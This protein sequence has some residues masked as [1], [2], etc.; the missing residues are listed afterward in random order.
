MLDDTD[1][2]LD[3]GDDDGGGSW[4]DSLRGWSR[5]L[6]SLV[7]F[8]GSLVFLFWN[9]SSGKQHADAIEE[10]GESARSIS[11]AAPLDPTL[12]GQPVHLS[13][14]VTSAGGVRDPFFG[15]R[16]NS[17][18]LF[19]NVAMFQW[20]EYKETRGKGTKRRT[21]YHYEQ[22]W[23]TSWHDSSRFHEPAGHQNPPMDLES[24]AFFAEDARFGPYRFTNQDVLE[25]ALHEYE[26][27]A[28]GERRPGSL[29]N[30]P[31]YLEQLPEL[32]AE[33]TRQRWF[34]IAPDEYY[35]GNEGVE[36]FEIG[37]L[38]VSYYAFPTDYTL[39]MIAGQH[40]DQLTAWTAGNGDTVLLA[41][42]GTLDAAAVITE[43]LASN[44]SRIA[45][46]RVVGLIGSM[47]GFVGMISSVAGLL[48]MIPGIGRLI[49]MSLVI[50]G[51]VI[52]LFL[53]LSTIVLGWLVARP[54]IGLLLLVGVIGIFGWGSWKQRLIRQ[55][56]QQAERIARA[57]AT[58][59]QRAAEKLAMPP[60]P[61][62][63]P[64]LAGAGAPIAALHQGPPP[65]PGQTRSSL[66][67]GT[68]PTGSAIPPPLPGAAASE[69]PDE[70]P[71]LE[72]VPGGSA[73]PPAVMPRRSDTPKPYDASEADADLPP[74][75]WQ[76]GPSQ[77]PPS[78]QP[79]RVDSPKP[80]DAV[81]EDAELPALDWPGSPPAA[82]T[83][84]TPD[85]ARAEAPPTPPAAVKPVPTTP[86]AA[87]SGPLWDEVEPRHEP[88]RPLWAQAT[89]AEEGFAG[90]PETPAEPTR[91]PA[92]PTTPVATKPAPTPAT[93]AV[94][95]ASKPTAAGQVLRKR[96]GSRGI[97]QINELLRRQPDGSTERVCFELMA[98]GKPIKRGSQAEVKAR[99]AELLQRGG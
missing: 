38:S 65:P 12:E 88:V 82:P 90:L 18:A 1:L 62:G 86:S 74:L 64:A 75:D 14:N 99:L 96:L 36:H 21:T 72:W 34:Q 57:T 60:L 37:D 67:P 56:K 83:A 81:D 69:E 2:D 95:A 43:A 46:F 59:R 41:A 24:E 92:E 25:Q 3:F 22:D 76:R 16:S 13:G 87:P 32:R 93:D 91:P 44:Q 61:D 48:G 94:A 10:A 80:Y 58:A 31:Q 4:L 35:R 71:P 11:A 17:V 8:L 7:I 66:P 42:G 47:I 5:P 40:G 79:R 9:E 53:G 73:Q 85:K 27:E 39:S 97:Y 49:E 28:G 33:R 70:L 51:M 19:R 78:V 98:N 54:W 29:G 6:F 30:W 23:D 20:I 89:L 52:G 15:I 68:T 77:A 63:S 26:E 50:S 45:F 84:A 55:A